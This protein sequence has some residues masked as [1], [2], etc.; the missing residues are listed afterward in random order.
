MVGLLELQRLGSTE[1]LTL[2]GLSML[3]LTLRPTH[4]IPT[5]S[6]PLALPFLYRAEALETQGLALLVR[7]H[8]QGLRLPEDLLPLGDVPTGHH[9]APDP[10]AVEDSEGV[11][12]ARTVEVG[13]VLTAG[14]EG[15]LRTC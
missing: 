6:T 2:P 3:V 13:M 15:T 8:H 7:S 5:P 11:A 14:P 1:H 9:V 4:G 10:G 12:G